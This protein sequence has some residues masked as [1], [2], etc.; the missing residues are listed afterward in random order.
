MKFLTILLQRTLKITVLTNLL[1]FVATCVL[2]NNFKL[3]LSYFK[4]TYI[5][6]Y[7]YAQG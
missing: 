7:F 4:A 5:Y 2:R 6:A 1:L 3:F